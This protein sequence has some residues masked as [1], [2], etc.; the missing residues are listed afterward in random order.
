MYWKKGD[1]ANAER[2][3]AEAA[4]LKSSRTRLALLIRADRG[5][6]TLTDDLRHQILESALLVDRGS[7]LSHR[8]PLFV[9]GYVALRDHKPEVALRYFRAV[10]GETP[11][12]WDIEPFETCLAD[13]LRELGRFDEAIAEYRRVLKLNVNY[14]MAR[15][16]LGLALERKGMN[17][18]ARAEFARFLTIW[19]DADPDVPELID[20]RRRYGQTSA[21]SAVKH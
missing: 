10:I 20:A 4:R 13:A 17:R 14:P 18:E 11:T 2:E 7:R 5:G 15:Y 9:A 12:W 3:A 19:K 8:F 6:L 21:F 16:R 1:L